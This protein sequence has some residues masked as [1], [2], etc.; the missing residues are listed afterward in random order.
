M[1]LCDDGHDEVA[2][3]GRECPACEMKRQRNEF[4]DK[5]ADARD[6]TES[7]RAELGDAND[8]KSKLQDDLDS[9]N[10]QIRNLEGA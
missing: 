3:E 6:L 8:A 10:E 1:R 5:L 9:A 2:H 4:E 7:L